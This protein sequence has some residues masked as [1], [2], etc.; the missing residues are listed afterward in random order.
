MGVYM[1]EGVLYR[2]LYYMAYQVLLGFCL[3]MFGV[4]YFEVI[5]L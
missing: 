3:I 1:K 5:A 4:K 2:S